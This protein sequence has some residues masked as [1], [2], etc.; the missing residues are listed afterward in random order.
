STPRPIPGTW[1]RTS[2]ASRASSCP[3]S[4]AS[5]FTGRSATPSPPRV[6]RASPSADVRGDAHPPPGWPPPHIRV[7]PCP[8]LA[9]WRDVGG[10]AADD[11]ALAQPLD[12]QVLALDVVD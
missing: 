3:T 12:S 2:P 8:R 11:G 4:A 9:V 5:V 7:T 6:T 10:T 1:A